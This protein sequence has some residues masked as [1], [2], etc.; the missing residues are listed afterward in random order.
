MINRLPYVMESLVV[1][2]NHA[3][4]AIVVV[5]Y[6]A[7]KAAGLNAEQAAATVEKSVAALNAK[8]PAYSQIARCELRNEPFEKTPKQ[9]IKRF[10]YN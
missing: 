5:D 7:A 1:G 9:S 10:M 6:D 4:I 3:I 2:R 8:L